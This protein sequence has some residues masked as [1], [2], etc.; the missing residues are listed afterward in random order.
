LRQTAAAAAAPFQTALPFFVPWGAVD[1]QD[2]FRLFFLL[3][4]Y[5]FF[6]LLEEPHSFR[7]RTFAQKFGTRGV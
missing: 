7:A 3:S 2:F 6:L 1:T 4:E 5:F